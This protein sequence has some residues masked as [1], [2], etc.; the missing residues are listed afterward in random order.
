MPYHF[1]ILPEIGCGN[2]GSLFPVLFSSLSALGD[3]AHQIWYQIWVFFNQTFM[4]HK[5]TGYKIRPDIFHMIENTALT[6]QFRAGRK[7]ISNEIGIDRFGRKG[8][9]HVRR[10]HFYKVYLLRFHPLFKHE[11]SDHQI[12]I[13]V[14]AGDGQGHSA[15]ISQIC[16][17]KIRPYHH[18]RAVPV[19]Q[20][21]NSNR[22][23]LFTQFHSQRYNHKGS[24]QTA[25]TD[26]LY[27]GWEILK[28]LRVVAIAVT[29][30]R[31]VIRYRAGKMTCY[32]QESH[33][34][35]LQRSRILERFKLPQFKA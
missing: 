17:I 7:R 6:A 28:S 18:S 10:R 21:N 1:N 3:T 34:N 11:P 32:R 19:A 22:Y 8:S 26:T 2:P 20:V 27:H 35:N 24:L 16:N 30:L 29:C 9:G 33:I 5:C 23:P 14:F 25:A 12:L 15:Q 31:G 4:Y 13:A